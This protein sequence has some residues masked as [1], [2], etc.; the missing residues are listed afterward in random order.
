MAGIYPD[1][2]RKIFDILNILVDVSKTNQDIV[3]KILD[4]QNR[5]SDT[6]KDIKFALVES[7]KK[8]ETCLTLMERL[9]KRVG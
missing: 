3:Y 7:N 9:E 8:I 1:D 4:N 5:N 2:L 6:M